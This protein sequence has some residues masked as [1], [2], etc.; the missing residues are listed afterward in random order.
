MP[1]S[2][3]SGTENLSGRD[4]FRVSGSGFRVHGFRDRDIAGASGGSGFGC[5]G[6]SSPSSAGPLSSEA[7]TIYKGLPESHGQNLA[8]TVLYVPYSLDSAIKVYQN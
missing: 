3:D 7:G 2:L 1:Y 5:T 4:G 6:A 8:L